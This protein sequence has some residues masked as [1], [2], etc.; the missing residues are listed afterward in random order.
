[1]TQKI[2]KNTKNDSHGTRNSTT[3][4]IETV[5]VI[6]RTL[7]LTESAFRSRHVAGKSHCQQT[8]A[9]T[10]SKYSTVTLHVLF[11]FGFEIF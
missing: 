6:I 4:K 3:I 5:F 7:L 8:G 2:S 1:M 11:I 9:V 10:I